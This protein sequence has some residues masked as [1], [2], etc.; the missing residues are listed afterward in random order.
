MSDEVIL[1]DQAPSVT[2]APELLELFE[3]RGMELHLV[4]GEI[5]FREGDL[6]SVAYLVT[7]GSVHVMGRA[8]DR[9][10]VVFDRLG[11]GHVFGEQALLPGP[12]PRQRAS[13]RAGTGCLLLALGLL[14][15]GRYVASD[16]AVAPLTKG[17]GVA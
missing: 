12:A 2:L 10:D 3:E 15:R 11:P 9:S 1:D 16:D 13:V 8:F 4:P 14:Q 17:H 6:S 5:V 7:S